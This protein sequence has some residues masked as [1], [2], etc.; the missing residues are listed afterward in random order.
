[1]GVVLYLC[2]RAGAYVNGE[3]ISVDSVARLRVGTHPGSLDESWREYR[4]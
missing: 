2:S 4:L 3:D 1:M